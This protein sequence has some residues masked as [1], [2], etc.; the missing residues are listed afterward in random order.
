MT[1]K[2]ASALASLLVTSGIVA[3]CATGT[4][5]AVPVSTVLTCSTVVNSTAY[6]GGPLT[7]DLAIA[8]LTDTQLTDGATNIPKGT[9]STADTTALD[10]AAAELIGYS[11]SKLSDDAA[12]FALA[13]EYYNPP[14]GPIDASYGRRL[15][16]DV[17]ALERDCPDGMKLG[18]QWRNAGI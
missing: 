15:D 1:A 13:E 7:A 6:R 4:G 12:A 5:P 2:N 16:N 11:G 10:A 14:D 3:G 18:R 17:L 9:P 8:F